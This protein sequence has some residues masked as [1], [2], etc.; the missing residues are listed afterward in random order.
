MRTLWS[1]PPVGVASTPWRRPCQQPA[2]S[3]THGGHRLLSVSQVLATLRA[4]TPPE[5]GTSPSGPLQSQAPPTPQLSLPCG[6]GSLWLWQ[7]VQKIVVVVTA[8]TIAD[9]SA[10]HELGWVGS[11]AGSGEWGDGL[12][13]LP[14]SASR[15][16]PGGQLVRLP[17]S[18]AVRAA[19]AD[20]ELDPPGLT[21][22]ITC[23]VPPL[24]CFRPLRSGAI[25]RQEAG[26]SGNNSRK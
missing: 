11:G 22:A 16:L 17:A 19:A 8:M 14:G 18:A 1:P 15:G 26:Q 6:A 10:T 13:C 24:G 2:Q 25:G 20:F 23:R 7:A 9:P 3:D 5:P 12:C 4:P 21:G